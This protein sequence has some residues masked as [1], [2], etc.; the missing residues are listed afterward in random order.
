MKMS[1]KRFKKL[2]ETMLNRKKKYR[3]KIK[4]GIEVEVGNKKKSLSQDGMY[5][6]VYRL[7][8]LVILLLN[9]SINI[10]Y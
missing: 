4:L 6:F 10:L 3:L 2:L 7:L 9:Y 1:N 8:I 5:D